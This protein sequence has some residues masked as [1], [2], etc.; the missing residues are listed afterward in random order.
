MP[1]LLRLFIQEALE[2]SILTNSDERQRI[3][4]ELI[5]HGADA[6]AAV[7]APLKESPLITKEK[8]RANKLASALNEIRTVLNCVDSGS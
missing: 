1:A 2:S 3:Y 6:A 7:F 5:A 4:A 8:A